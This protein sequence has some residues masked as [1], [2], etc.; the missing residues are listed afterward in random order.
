MENLSGHNQDKAYTHESNS[1]GKYYCPMHCEG[2]KTYDK[3][4][5]CPVCNMHLIPVNG[6][7]SGKEH[8]QHANRHDNPGL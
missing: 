2:D 5:D 1:E 3:Q 4:G 8:E 7:K 6:Q